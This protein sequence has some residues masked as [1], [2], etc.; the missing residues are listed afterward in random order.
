MRLSINRR[1]LLGLP[2]LLALFGIGRAEAQTVIGAGASSGGGSGGG[3]TWLLVTADP[4]NALSGHGYLANTTGGPFTVT[5]PAA[6]SVGDVVGIEDALGTFGTNALT[7]GRNSLA[8]MG[9]AA[10]MT[11]STNNASFALVYEGVAGGW[12]LLWA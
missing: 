12:R 5:L 2:A 4:A 7:I 9:L 3:L 10:N 8:I 6:P 11:V 1:A